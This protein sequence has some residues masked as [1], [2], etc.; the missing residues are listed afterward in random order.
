GRQALVLADHLRP[1]P[2][3]R[4]RHRAPRPRPRRGALRRL[5]LLHVVRRVVVPDAGAPHRS[6]AN[7][8]AVPE[9]TTPTAAPVDDAATRY[10]S[11]LKRCL[12]RDLFVDEEVVD[13]LHWPEGRMFV[14][15]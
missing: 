15:P 11:L 9:P 2:G 3:P 5:R 1:R 8:S 6:R 7:V 12:T 10:L 14:P 13:V 4:A